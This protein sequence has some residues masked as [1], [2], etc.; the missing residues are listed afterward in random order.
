[1]SRISAVGRPR[2]AIELL[3][4][5]LFVRASD[6]RRVA[7]VVTGGLLA[8]AILGWVA[9]RVG[10]L[11]GE[12]VVHVVEP[13]VEVDV[14]GHTFVIEGPRHEPV[15]CELPFGRHDLAM[16]RAG[17]VLYLETFEVQPDHNTVLVAFDPA[18]LEGGSRPGLHAPAPQPRP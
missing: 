16:S 11:T 8:L 17:R 18:R 7:R 15:V 6:F 9:A 13:D 2:S 3:T 10:T 5:K 1:V 12:V 4:P 14:G